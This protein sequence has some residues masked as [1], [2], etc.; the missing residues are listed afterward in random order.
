MRAIAS[1]NSW[2]ALH[3]GEF[4]W[5]ASIG[6]GAT[7]VVGLA[8][9][10]AQRQPKR[11]AWSLTADAALL[12]APHVP[13]LEALVVM[14]GGEVVTFPRAIA[15]R[16]WNYGKVEISADDDD[17]EVPLTVRISGPA[18]KGVYIADAKTDWIRSNTTLASTPSRRE[19]T[20][21]TRALHRGDGS[22]FARWWMA[23][24][25]LSSSLTHRSSIRRTRSNSLRQTL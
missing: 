18:V 11:L 14:Y 4:L 23:R 9:Y 19:T 1:G 25:S 12:A 6:V 21:F 8:I 13:E 24:R 22:I 7:P 5:G 3:G 15:L 2:V 16:I 10:W 20:V 17:Y